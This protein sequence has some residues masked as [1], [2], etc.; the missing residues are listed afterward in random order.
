MNK[1]TLR[2]LLAGLALSATLCA[3][4]PA[5]QPAA[6]APAQTPARRATRG[7]T[8][9][10][11]IKDDTGGIIPGATVTLSTQNGT[12]Q[13]VQSGGDGTYTFRNVPPGSYTV[14]AT[15]AGLQQEGGALVNVTGTQPVTSNLTMTVQAQRQE[16]T[17]TDTS[18]NQVS[19][20]PAN[21]ASALVLKQEDLDALP[22]DPDDLEADLQALAGPAAGPGGN[23]IFVDGFSGGRLPPKESI[24]EI[25]INSNP[26]SAE[27][28]K[29]GYGRIQIFTKPGS[30]KFHGQGYYNISDGI[31]NSRNPFLIEKGFDD[32]PFRTQ[33]FGG[34]LSG[35]LGKH[36]SFFIDVER[37][38][39]DDN[40]IVTATIPNT[41]FTG[42]SPYQIYY[43]TPQ[44]RTTVSPRVDY[45]L[46]A[47]NTLSFRYSYLAND[48]VLTG[49]GGFD[50]PATTVGGITFPSYGYTSN[51][52]ENTLQA[53]E[54]A[55]LSTKVVNETHLQFDHTYT[56][57][58]SQSTAPT[59][60]VS[61]A[62][63]AGGSGYSAPG[64]PKSYTLQNYFELQNYTSVTWRTHVTKFG[65]RSRTTW[66]DNLNVTGFNG[67]YSFL[68]N[69][70]ANG[71]QVS[72][73]QDYLT[74][75]QLLNQGL[76]SAQVTGMG[77]GPSKYTQNIGSPYISLHQWDYGPFIQDDWK[78]RSNLTL[79]V[80]LRWEDQT[81]IRD[82]TDFAPRFGFAWSPDSK[83]TTGR[84][85]TVIRGGWG[86]FYDRF[87][88]TNVE[89][90][91]RYAQGNAYQT[92]TLDA[93]TTYNAAFN[94]QIPLSV[95]TSNGT[96]STA[97]QRFQ[98]DSNFKAPRIM[99]TAV[100]ID[101]QLLAHTTLSLNFMNS[102]GLHE[103]RTVDI[104]A[105]YECPDGTADCLPS[106][107]AMPPRLLANSNVIGARPYGNIGDIYNYESDGVFK[108]TQAI[109]GINSTVGKY[110]TIFAR[111]SFTTAHSDTDG[112]NTFPADPYYFASDWGRSS[113]DMAHSFFLGGSVTAPWGL[114]F[115]PF[116]VAHS[117]TPF[118][119]TAGTD[120]YLQGLQNTPSARPAVLTSAGT[121][122]YYYGIPVGCSGPGID[123]CLSTASG[124]VNA[125]D[126]I[127]RNSGTG[128]GFLGFNLRVSKTFG[129]GTTKFA[130]PSGGSRGGGGGGGGGGHG[131]GGGGGGGGFGGFGG[132]GARGGPGAENTQH[133]YNL[134][135]SL[136]ARNILNHENLSPPV[137]A[138]TSPYFL[139]STGITG[140]YGAE[141]TASN[142]RRMDIQLRFA[143]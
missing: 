99:Q 104:N 2:V 139:E 35:P 110:A 17:V 135:I 51:S 128:P 81:N 30:D 62:F 129:F 13:T 31:W 25:R 72:S 67:E 12:V 57:D 116:L 34:N 23:Q 82:Y 94:T 49:I 88:I 73:I 46:G 9:S 24:R 143:F 76:S 75:V 56:T 22:D 5:T 47:N 20:D 119:V 111:Y 16:V 103:P 29:L 112:L 132:G 124:I 137:G 83:A 138:I 140:G 66:M 4:S 10:G 3:Q 91:L 8:I 122:N 107:T 89:T 96:Q 126:M 85:K 98:I 127:E 50:V 61:Q 123:P 74:T 113:L 64:T 108:Q 48:H 19:T 79:S 102:R 44:R 84:A 130:G 106:P 118:N 38:Q 27:F 101:R 59:L 1:L 80:G 131:G 87:A 39:I 54:T 58:A 120:L 41:T 114:R 136:N 37:R 125:T 133:R 71:T 21:N 77:Y 92:Y 52:T 45:Q 68:G 7:A 65:V 26:F 14:S 78:A 70:L 40:G 69:T 93:P 53:V 11:S 15:Y 28:D 95:L 60:D 121:F 6:Q 55:V 97:A 36:A 109:V 42:T 33:L 18:T 141:A 100:G 134:T 105:P 63:V 43:S 90:A 142:Q 117:G 86:M 115:S 32:P